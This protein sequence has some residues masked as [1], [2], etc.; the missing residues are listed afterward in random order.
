MREVRRKKML[1]LQGRKKKK[2][3]SITL[4]FSDS[5]VNLKSCIFIR[6]WGCVCVGGLDSR[7]MR[8]TSL[9]NCYI[10]SFE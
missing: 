3:E 8:M 7:N 2:H 5:V 4:K 1:R 9:Y 6:I 10:I